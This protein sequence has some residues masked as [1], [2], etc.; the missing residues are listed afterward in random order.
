MCT[1]VH[2]PLPDRFVGMGGVVCFLLLNKAPAD[3]CLLLE[4]TFAEVSFLSLS[5]FHAIKLSKQ[6][7]R[8]TPILYKS[9][10]DHL[11]VG[12]SG[13]SDGSLLHPSIT[14]PPGVRVYI[15]ISTIRPPWR[16]IY[17]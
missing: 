16:Q 1:H 2:N 4:L 5:A 15:S 3:S 17:M 9:S 10:R 13:V 14:F 12:A 11:F 6:L 8:T 7:A